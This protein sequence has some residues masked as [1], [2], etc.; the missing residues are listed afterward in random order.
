M[1]D[2]G[3]RQDGQLQILNPAD[4]PTALVQ[5]VFEFTRRQPAFRAAWISGTLPAPASGREYQLLFFMEPR[6]EVIFHDLNMIIQAAR[7]GATIHLGLLTG[8][9]V[10][11]IAP[12]APPFFTAPD[13]RP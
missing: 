11:R 10:K 13:Y 3:E 1:A 2:P 9:D 6:D 12:G 8:D 7:E 4:Y 5:A